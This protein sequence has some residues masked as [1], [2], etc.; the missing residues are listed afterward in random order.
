MCRGALLRWSWSSLWLLALLVT[1]TVSA[2]ADE[3]KRSSPRGEECKHPLI[4]TIDDLRVEAGTGAGSVRIS[5][6]R[7]SP[8]EGA[9]AEVV[10]EYCLRV[11]PIVS[12]TIGRAKPMRL[13][14]EKVRGGGRVT[15]R[16]A[17]LPDGQTLQLVVRGRARG[18]IGPW[19]MGGHGIEVHVPGYPRADH[20]RRPTAIRGA[21]KLGRKGAYY[22]LTAD[23]H[24]PGTA[25]EIA[26]PG[27]TLD[28]GGHTIYY[29]EAGG[30]GV[31]GVLSRY[32]YAAHNRVQ[33]LNGSIVYGGIAGAGCDAI[34]FQGGHDVLIS[35]IRIVTSSPNSRG[36]NLYQ[37]K[38][39]AHSE[40]RV[41]HCHVRLEHD[42]V[43]NRHQ[44]IEA[45]NI[46]HSHGS[47]E[48][49]HCLVSAAPQWGICVRGK[50][51]RP[52]ATVLIH[53]NRVMGTRSNTVNG[54]MVGVYKPRSQVFYNMLD[55]ESRGIHVDGEYGGGVDSWVFGNVVRARVRPLRAQDSYACH[56]IKLEHADG[57]TVI[58]NYVLVTS[59]R[60]YGP[61]IALDLDLEQVK[62]VVVRSNCF[63]ASAVGAGRRAI[64]LNLTAG[65]PVAGEVD[66][67]GNTYSASTILAARGWEAGSGVRL[68]RDV[69]TRLRAP[70]DIREH[71][72]E[73]FENSHAGPSR[74]HRFTDPL[75]LEDTTRVSQWMS[76]AP[77]ESAREWTVRV[78]AQDEAAKPLD[79]AHVAVVDQEGSVVAEGRTSSEGMCHLLVETMRVTNGPKISLLGPVQVRVTHGGRT[80]SSEPLRV[81]SMRSLRAAF[82]DARITLD[83]DA[84]TAPG[85]LRSLSL[86]GHRW[87]LRWK[88]SSDA[89]GVA[90]YILRAD[91]TPLA[92]TSVCECVV[93]ERALN[94]I[95]GL[96]L[97][98]VDTSGNYSA[99]SY[100]QLGRHTADK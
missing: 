5:F 84:P 89:S 36:I 48:V 54:Y 45:I 55:G 33:I 30:D 7:P 65:G 52:G 72:F 75:T 85:Q 66:L 4:G 25:I 40:I 49:D 27:I 22:L 20:P 47:V 83:V 60:D 77:F 92:V 14:L 32:L 95:R 98:S 9:P 50:I 68:V 70:V 51:T 57:A 19:S 69:W 2:Q 73:L 64:A 56:G 28:L 41:S 46:A 74:N 61:A 79:A 97:Q 43:H 15:A 67:G 8:P 90:H 63:S 91:N 81:R 94:G 88:P 10:Y 71:W 23:I 26:A 3:K 53:H 59:G 82:G 38:Q 58:G 78:V 80:I 76:S 37:M 99:R 18:W 21:A 11:R 62:S 44:G 24:S 12:G 17:G 31:H 35:R 86:G 39:D 16:M 34:R 42:V 29:G 87:L 93:D 1:G 13:L 96:A 100:H 6:T